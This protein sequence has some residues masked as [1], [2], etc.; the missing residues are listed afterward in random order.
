MTVSYAAPPPLFAAFGRHQYASA[1]FVCLSMWF[2][3]RMGEE[4]TGQ[5]GESGY[6][7]TARVLTGGRSAPP[8]RICVCA[9]SRGKG[10]REQRRRG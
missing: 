5:G 10:K 4:K 2:V 6:Q 7:G 1:F 9:K 8:R 3:A